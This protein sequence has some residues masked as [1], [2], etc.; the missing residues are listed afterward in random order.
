VSYM[1]QRFSPSLVYVVTGAAHDPLGQPAE[2]G[3]G[4]RMQS[5]VQ[6]AL[7]RTF[8]AEPT[9]ERGKWRQE[10][11]LKRSRAVSKPYLVLVARGQ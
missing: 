7:N 4:G 6:A 10:D 8:L 9:S 2:A 11:L 1:V 3:L 5:E